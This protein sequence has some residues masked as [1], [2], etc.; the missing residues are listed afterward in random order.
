MLIHVDCFKTIDYFLFWS[1]NH[2]NTLSPIFFYKESKTESIFQWLQ[3]QHIFWKTW[4]TRFHQK[5][6]G[7]QKLSGHRYK[8]QRVPTRNVQTAYGCRDRPFFHKDTT[9]KNWWQFETKG[10][11]LFWDY[12]PWPFKSETE[13]LLLPSYGGF[14]S[15]SEKHLTD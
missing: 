15:R 9:A 13:I 14:D 10:V 8:F 11:C 5:L 2:Y 3:Q 12:N 7:F 6:G 4:L 1:W